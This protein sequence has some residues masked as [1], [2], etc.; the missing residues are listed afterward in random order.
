MQTNNVLSLKEWKK[1]IENAVEESS[2]KDYFNVLSFND[3]INETKLVVNELNDKPLSEEITK[4][5]RLILKEFNERLEKESDGF[6]KVLTLLRENVEEK[7]L[8]LRSIQQL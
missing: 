2:M 5:S 8:D 7:I 4:K 6:A 1:Q 3:L